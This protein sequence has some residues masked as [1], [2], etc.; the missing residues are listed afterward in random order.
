MGWKGWLETSLEELNPEFSV[1]IL[2]IR[3][4]GGLL[5]GLRWAGLKE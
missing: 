3:R 2:I 1:L 5:F 4:M